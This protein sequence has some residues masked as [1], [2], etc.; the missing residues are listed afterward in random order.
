MSVLVLGE[1]DK[2]SLVTTEEVQT[3]SLKHNLILP[4]SELEDWAT[5]LTGLNHCA[6]EVL[7]IPDYFPEVNTTLYPRTNIY[8]PQGE[9]ETD[10]GGWATKVTI[11]CT[12]PKSHELDGKTFAIKDAIAVA[13][14]QCTNGIGGKVGEWIPKVD[15]TLVTRILDAGGV[16]S[17]K[18]AC[19]A[20][21]LVAVSDT[22]ITGNVHN[23]YAYGYSIGG[24]SSGSARLVATG[25]V[26]MSV[27]ADQGGSV[28]K[29]ST[30]CGVV[31]M[32]P[33]WGLVPYT[34]CL[35]LEATLD[36]AGPMARNVQD[37]ATLLEVIAGSDGIDDVSI[38]GVLFPLLGLFRGLR[39]YFLVGQLCFLPPP[40]LLFPQNY[41]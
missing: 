30:N 36:H 22:S 3:L 8:R 29:P 28:R 17:G 12:A 10:C 7:Q 11:K 24:S 2:T 33:T 27:G 40:I 9:Q 31:G 5:L 32:K 6:K 26:D 13:G 23:P 35:S 19:E 14:V 39:H 38:L 25:Q 16:I 21:C 34:G 15:A 18:S 41:F 20:G 4:P 37:C 1:T